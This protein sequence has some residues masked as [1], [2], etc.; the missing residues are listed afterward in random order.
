MESHC[1]AGKS[2]GRVVLHGDLLTRVWG[3]GFEND[4][5]YL[6]VWVSRLR[7]KLE[8][9]RNDPKIVVTAMVAGYRL[10]T[11]DATGADQHAD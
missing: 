5:A 4:M 9:D 7:V 1:R 3:A 11:T 6:R 10:A 2:A 8:D